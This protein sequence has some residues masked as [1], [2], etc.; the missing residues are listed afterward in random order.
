MKYII[1]QL[2]G[3]NPIESKNIIVE[4]VNVIITDVNGIKYGLPVKV[5]DLNIKDKVLTSLNK[6]YGIE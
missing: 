4:S 6:Q 3:V 2:N 5:E 1:E